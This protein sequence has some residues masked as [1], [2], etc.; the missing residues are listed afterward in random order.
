MSNDHIFTVDCD[1]HIQELPEK[2]APYCAMPWRSSLEF[3]AANPNTIYRRFASIYE[4]LNLP[5]PHEYP[6]RPRIDTPARMREELDA[7]EIDIG[8]L[9]PDDLLNL[10]LYPNPDEAL[11]L[12]RAYNEWMIDYWLA[13]E[14]GLRGLL[15]AVPQ[16]PEAT[17]RDIERYARARNVVGIFLP[18]AA[19]DPLYGNR[20]YGPIYQAA[21]DADLPVLLHA[22]AKVHGAFPFNLHH[23]ET[24]LARHAVS[25]P[26][27][28]MANL[29]SLIN[30]GVVVRFPRLKFAFTEA[31]VSWVPFVMY[32][33]DKE[34][35][36]R[37]REVPFLEDRPSTYFKRFYFATQ[38]IEEPEP[39]RDLVSLF[40]LFNGEDQVMFASDWPHEDFDH[41]NKIL[42]APFSLEAKRKIMGENAIRFFNLKDIKKD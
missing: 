36:E 26:F 1:V 5:F 8:M 33:L 31:G 32:R 17:A 38:P 13:G 37:R 3:L 25:H 2:L 24:T 10:A 21:Q 4:T 7:L 12:G 34:Y 15:I 14:Y 29:I 20:R 11:A 41:P 22:T 30:T 39:L 28:M 9:F 27:S 40:K 18:A 23:F 19:V 16:D 35:T 42:E 6:S